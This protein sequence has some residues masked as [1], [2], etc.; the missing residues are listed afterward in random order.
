MNNKIEEFLI[1]LDSYEEKYEIE[2]WQLRVNIY[3]EET[4][5]HEIANKFQNLAKNR[6]PWD[7]S[8]QQRGYLEALIEKKNP[9]DKTNKS[10]KGID[11]VNLIDRIGREL[12]STMTYSDIQAYLS[13]FGVD[14]DIPTTDNGGSKWV[15][16]KDLLAKVPDKT[17]F[18]IA[19]ELEI[20]HGYTYHS[21]FEIPDSKF[22]HP[23][24]LRLFLS[25]ISTFKIRTAQLQKMLKEYGISSFVAHEDI[26]PTQEW[27]DEIEK[28]LHSMDALCAILTPKFCESKWTD[29]EIGVA[30]GR[31]VLVIPIR[32][33]IDPYGFIGKYQGMQGDGKTLGQVAEGIFKILSSHPKTKE[34]LAGALVDQITLANNK[35][36][37][38]GK[39]TLLRAIEALP[40]K[41]LEKIS[42]NC[43]ENE[44]IVGSTE[45]IELLNEMLDEREMNRFKI[46]KT[47]DSSFSDDI[48]F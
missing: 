33:G 3:L 37:A 32:K 29:Q 11:R 7:G 17:I 40:K 45:F 28:A 10:M 41:H 5:G 4:L 25:H 1:Q 27:Q 24:H 18:K 26:E 34:I 14:T 21:T 6:N 19:D 9:L 48:P 15:Y 12:Q 2:R 43:K 22:W 44:L 39:L 47:Q 13:G 42:E 16:V 38:M 20:Y 36:E 8:A 30:V 31:N 35:N 23:N 46:I